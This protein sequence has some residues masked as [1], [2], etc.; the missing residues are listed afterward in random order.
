MEQKFVLSKTMF[1]FVCDYDFKNES[2]LYRLVLVVKQIS[3]YVVRLPAICILFYKILINGPSYSR[4]AVLINNT[5]KTVKN[6]KIQCKDKSTQIT[7]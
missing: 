5:C 3:P 4:R 2:I 6:E 1:I 7:G